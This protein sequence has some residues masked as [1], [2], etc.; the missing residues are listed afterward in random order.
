M[1]EYHTL[2]KVDEAVDLAYGFASGYRMWRKMPV[3]SNV[4]L[5][6]TLAVMLEQTPNHLAPTRFVCSKSYATRNKSL[7]L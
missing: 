3:V 4:S 5:R 2:K 6:R 1:S 7:L